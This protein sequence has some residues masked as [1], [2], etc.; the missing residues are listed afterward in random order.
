MRV[1]A[2]ITAPLLIRPLKILECFRQGIDRSCDERVPGFRGGLGRVTEDG[3]M[4]GL[5]RGRRM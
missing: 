3:R 4:A 5:R 2:R 1:G